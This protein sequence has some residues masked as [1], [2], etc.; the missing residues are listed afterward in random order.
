[1]FEA[2][3]LVRLLGRARQACTAWARQKKKKEKAKTKTLMLV[4]MAIPNERKVL[5]IS[6]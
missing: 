3:P 5:P 6:T 4:Y 2:K 1:M